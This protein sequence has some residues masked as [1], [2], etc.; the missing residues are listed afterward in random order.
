MGYTVS[1]VAKNRKEALERIRS[2]SVDLVLIDIQLK[3]KVDGVHAS[4]DIQSRFDVPVVFLSDAPEEKMLQQIRESM[5]HGFLLKPYK[6]AEL[7]SEIEIA[8]SQHDQQKHF[9]SNEMRHR[10][11]LM[12]LSC[13]VLLTDESGKLIFV[14]EAAFSKIP[15]ISHRKT[16]GKPL[17][18]VIHL[19][20]SESGL[21]TEGILHQVIQEGRRI[22]W[23]LFRIADLNKK[24]EMR[25]TGECAPITNHDHHILGMVFL[26][27]PG[28]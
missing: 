4:K 20:Q 10:L 2:V 27:Q 25:L 12:S 13:G 9:K 1:G 17:Q 7:K 15:F 24:N 6:D 19:T 23:S 5:P 21:N 16:M 3:K 14:N 11:A 28:S 8:L 22:A 18:Q 26:F